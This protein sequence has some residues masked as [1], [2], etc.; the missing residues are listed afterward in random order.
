MRTFSVSGEFAEKILGSRGRIRILDAL[1]EE[2]ELNISQLSRRVGMNHT[3]VDG[4]VKKLKELG[5]VRERWYGKIRML[6][7]DFD[8]VNIRF[9]KGFGADLSI[10]RVNRR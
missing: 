8:E 4:H 5:L 1:A 6:E 3:C 10:D 9:K 7:A 2:G